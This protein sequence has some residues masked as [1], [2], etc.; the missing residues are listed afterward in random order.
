MFTFSQSVGLFYFDAIIIYFYSEFGFVLEINKHNS[1]QF[2]S[3]S[4]KEL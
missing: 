1:K 2:I 4:D 3:L